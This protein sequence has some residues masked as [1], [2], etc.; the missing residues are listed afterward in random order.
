MKYGYLYY[1][2]G[3]LDNK[4]E[5]PMNLGDPIQSLATIGIL[6]QIGIP[7]ENIIPIDRYDLAT[8]DGEEVIMIVNGAE[9]YEHYAYHTRFL[10]VSEKIIPVFIG[11]H[12]HR[13]LSEE[14]LKSFCEHQP[15]GCR[16]ENTVSYL[17]S[18]GIDAFLTGCLTLTFPRRQKSKK[19]NK[20]F[21]VDCA[22]SVLQY[23]PEHLRKDAVELSQIIRIA[24]ETKGNRLTDKE[25]E[26]Y[27]EC[28]EKQLRRFRDEAALVITSRLHVATPC[29]AMGIPVV[30]IRDVFDERFQFINR[31]LPLYTPDEYSDIDWSPNT[32]IPEMVKEKIVLLCESMLKLAEN[33]KYMKEIYAVHP[34]KVSFQLEEEVA[35]QSLPF[36]RDK[37]FSYAIW[38]VCMPNSYLLYEVM[39]KQFPNARMVCAVDTWATGEYK[40]SIPIISPD[41][42]DEK[43]DK[44]TV[45]LVVAPAAHD[46]AVKKIEGRY[47]YLL[48]KGACASYYSRDFG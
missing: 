12:L 38:G 27:V 32:Q 48:L 26:Y 46:V 11:I 43:L 19:Q 47:D 36:L 35:V 33:R 44:D 22:E 39:Q 13:E 20:V 31:F 10:P 4:K 3:L 18:K 17:K 16:D 28:A 15:I 37:A 30:L 45:I 29:A 2:K 6:K 1:R 23:I 7:E 41:E 24:S 14:E 8:Y 34:R 25:T 21:L 9:N 42:L 5:R 40:D